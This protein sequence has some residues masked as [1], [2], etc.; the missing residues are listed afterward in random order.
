[1]KI[2]FEVLSDQEI[3]LLH[4]SSVRVLER[5]GM[6]F[7][8]RR[9]LERLSALGAK[10]DFGERI[11]RLPPRMIEEAIAANQ[12]SLRKGKRF[13]L[14]NG[15]TSELTD[16]GT[17]RAKVSGGCEKYLDWDSMTVRQADAESLLRLVRLGESLPEVSFVGNPL[18]MRTDAGGNPIEERLRR[19][20]TAALIAKNTRKLGSMEV[21]SEKEIDLLVEIAVIAR[22]SR[23]AFDESPC[24]VTAKETIS[25]LFLDENAS[26]ILI[27]LAARDLPCTIIPMPLTGM[28]APA[29][30]LGN[31]IVGNAEILGIITAVKAFHPEALVGGGAISGLLDMKTGSV[32][33]SAPEAILQD[34][35]I[36]EVH[37]RLYGFDF[38]VGSGYTDAKVPGSQVPAEKLSKFLFTYLSGRSS[39]PVGLVNSGS[40]FRDVQCLVD[41]EICRSIH[42]YFGSF[43]DFASCPD[44]VGLIDSVGVQGS[45]VA[46]DHTLGHFRESWMP[47]LLDRTSFSSFDDS[48]AKDL[49][50]GAR[51]ELRRFDS[52]HDFWHIDAEKERAIDEVV[53]RAER[54]L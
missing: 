1:M 13:H 12:A 22:G 9:V 41:I 44:L 48:R 36:A 51:A 7:A 8:S 50:E 11:A 32:S 52:G 26:D 14:L 5:T 17:I 18:V 10:V 29:T 6:R 16:R 38:L 21:W 34:I 2:S 15:V 3:R 23:Q 40:V 42:G 24:L 19:I 28:S 4:E 37:Q 20:S 47:W 53:T 45:Y 31:A 25:P 27:A 35:A 43:G 49:Y 30:K 39:Y 46:E 54:E 33:F